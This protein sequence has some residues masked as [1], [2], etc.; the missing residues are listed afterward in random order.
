MT[1]TF[2]WLDTNESQRRQM[3]EVVALFKDEGT[4][5]E[6]G[7]GTVRDAI[8]NALFPGLSVLHT[9]LR[10][11]LFVPWLVQAA[12]D[13]TAGSAQAARRL[14]RLETEL[15]DSLIRGTADLGDD[16]WGVIGVSA[17][18]RLRRMP[19][20]IFWAVLGRWGI[21]VW[22]ESADGLFRRGTG[23]RELAA[24]R[25]RADDPE[26][27]H[28]VPTSGF[29]ASLPPAPD[30]LLERTDFRLTAE[31]AEFLGHQ[32]R[33]STTGSLL[34]WLVDHPPTGDV[35]HVWDLP[36]IEHAPPA[37]VSLVDH[38]RRLHTVVH[39]AALLYNL[40]LAEESGSQD[41]T[42]DY[43]EALD[44]WAA[45]VAAPD[46]LDGWDRD[47]FWATLLTLNPRISRRTRAFL[48]GWIDL[49]ATGTRVAESAAARELVR[50][51]E[52]AIKGARARLGNRAALDQWSGASGL[53]RLDYRW[54]VAHRL[55]R[56]LHQHEGTVD[57]DA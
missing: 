27:D 19:S 57:A 31:E 1:S 24:A 6:I 18:G 22:D 45:E 43:N 21:R 34:A 17:R 54:R 29:V 53:V 36:G 9:R 4:I 13:H 39:G 32:I 25:P 51:R 33:A 38:G 41:L 47:E 2:G 35:E 49:L 11:V 26:A 3:M 56:D 50:L 40:M 8:A 14:R 30:G 16:G 44:V 28:H 23:M 46:V 55:L 15:I 52:H 42:Q 20:A 37:M 48:D 7:I 10:Y 12:Q 5:D